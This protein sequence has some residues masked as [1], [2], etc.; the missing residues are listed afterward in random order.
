[1]S[2]SCKGVL[3]LSPQLLNFIRALTLPTLFPK[4]KIRA[5]HAFPK[6]LH[7]SFKHYTI[8]IEITFNSATSLFA[9]MVE[10][11]NKK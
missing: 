5:R 9:L 6:L 8:Q 1:M 10:F 7:W 11:E 4:G 2:L 3:S